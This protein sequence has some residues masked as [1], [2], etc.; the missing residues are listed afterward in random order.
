MVQTDRR[1]LPNE[2]EAIMAGTTAPHAGA[3]G[4]V[5]VTGTSGHL[6]EALAVTLRAMG[7]AVAGIDILH[8]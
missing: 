6:G 7:A 2:A 5:L 3:L 1:T 8:R 4:R